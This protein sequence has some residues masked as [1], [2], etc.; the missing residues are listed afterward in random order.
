MSYK[1]YTQIDI[2]Q[3]TSL[4]LKGETPAS[5]ARIMN[6]DRHSIVKVLKRLNIYKEP[7]RIKK[8][9]RIGTIVNGMRI[10]SVTGK[11]ESNSSA[12]YDAKCVRCGYIMHNCTYRQLKVRSDN[13]D[14]L[15]KPSDYIGQVFGS[16]KVLQVMPYRTN[17]NQAVY[18]VECIRCGKHLF[19][20]MQ[21]IKETKNHATLCSHA[22]GWISKKLRDSFRSAVSRC[23]NPRDP[24]YYRYG[25]RGITVYEEWLKD[26]MAF[27]QWAIDNGWHE[28]LTIDRINIDGNYCPSNCRWVPFSVNA[29]WTS[30]SSHVIIDD[31]EDTW[32][33]WAKRIGI[34]PRRIYDYKRKNGIDDTIALIKNS[35]R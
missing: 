30:R 13:C 17:Y 7:V 33:G 20:Q 18:E 4:Y 31:V 11:V 34:D 21:Q 6:K 27:Q 22:V 8:E 28:G 32:S 35:W 3:I 9:D 24:Y 23:M 5:I 25:G 19:M 15:H 1:K 16:Y 10:L 29:K 2:E 26:P 14:H 12:L